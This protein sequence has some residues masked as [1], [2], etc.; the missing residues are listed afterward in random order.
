M[1]QAACLMIELK[2][3][4]TGVLAGISYAASGYV[5]AASR[6]EKF[7]VKKFFRAVLIGA[8]IGGIS[9]IMKTPLPDAEMLLSQLGVTAVIDKL[10]SAIYEKVSRI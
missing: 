5:R 8:A 6:G 7:K 9:V 2:A 3:L 10:A 1:R 4:A